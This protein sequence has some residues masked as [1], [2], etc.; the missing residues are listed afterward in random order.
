M[1]DLI[2]SYINF[3]ILSISFIVKKFAFL[4]PDPPKYII[5]KEKIKI[6]IGIE[7]KED[8]L[9]LIKKDQLE[10][11]KIK[12]KYLKIEYSKI[13]L[14]NGYLPILIIS[15]IFHKP[16]CIIYCQGNSGDLGTSLFECYEISLKCNCNIITFEYPGYGVCKKDEIKEIEFFKRIKIVYN[17]IIKNLNFKPNQIILYG[18]SLGTGIAFDFACKK[19]YPVAG[20]ILQSPFLSIIR[21]IYN[22]KTTKYFDLFNNC[23]KAKNL[24]RK[25]FFIHGN[26]DTIVPYLH[27]RI[28]AKL[29]PN[30][31]FYDFLTVDGADH[32]N[33]LK[34]KINKE[35]VFESIN[36]FILYCTDKNFF[37]DTSSNSYNL[38]LPENIDN[39]EDMIKTMDSNNLIIS[40]NS[41]LKSDEI[42]TFKTFIE[43]K[44]E[45]NIKTNSCI[46]C[47]LNNI[48]KFTEN[49]INNKNN[50]QNGNN[51]I[52]IN[53]INNNINEENMRYGNQIYNNEN[54]IIN[55]PQNLKQKNNNFSRN[56]Y[57]A[58]IATYRRNNKFALYKKYIHNPNNSQNLTKY[59]SSESSLITMNSSTNNITNPNVN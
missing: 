21:T 9:F 30:K 55:L 34:L 13:R 16:L 2:I 8:I 58:D 43:Q 5:E 49:V 24:C 29:I 36:S 57:Y 35:I 48:K 39:N 47:P 4:P 17:Y 10:Y 11:K 51:I 28:L 37:S 22:I 7:E 31:Y 3:L 42:R 53:N 40:V 18:F 33:L 56:Y 50:I 12:P 15:P 19:E 59:I 14:F 27:G 45:N 26:K 44:P 46:N 41:G 54:N 25:T 52:K 23:D 38:D 1:L 32:N 20:L 6:G